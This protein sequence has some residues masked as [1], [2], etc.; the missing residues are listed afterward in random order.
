MHGSFVSNYRISLKIWSF[1]FH[2]TIWL[3][4]LFKMSLHKVYE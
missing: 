2:H 4:F 1:N 3:I